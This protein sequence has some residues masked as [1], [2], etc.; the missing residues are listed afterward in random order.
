MKKILFLFLIILPG[1]SFAQEKGFGFRQE[2]TG[3]QSEDWHRFHLDQKI[4]SRLHPG[5]FDLRIYRIN[6]NDTL[7][8]PYILDQGK[9]VTIQASSIRIL[10]ENYE[11][12]CCSWVSFELNREKPVNRLELDIKNKEFDKYLNLEGSED[13]KTWKTIKEKVRITR[14]DNAL[15]KFNHTLIS[16]PAGK[17]RMLRVAF[18]DDNSEKLTVS[19][20]KAWYTR[21]VEKSYDLLNPDVQYLGET[22]KGITSW[23]IRF[24]ERRRV[25]SLRFIPK[26]NSEYFRSINFLIPATST[27]ALQDWT[28]VHTGTIS[29]LDTSQMVMNSTFTDSLR[30]DVINHDNLSPEF[31]AIEVYSEKLSLVTRL[32]GEG[33]LYLYYGSAKAKEPVYDLAWFAHK[34]PSELPLLQT[35]GEESLIRKEA[36]GEKEDSKIWLWIVIAG[37]G[38]LL[39]FYSTRMLKGVE[40]PK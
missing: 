35:G 11:K 40:P 36:E 29:S 2:L 18:D 12:K 15:A 34:I 31:D 8:M 14:I 19:G 25:S 30:V 3:Q 21:P 22:K 4:I 32:S 10:N 33:A 39:L 38:A 6:G 24:P 26:S 5:L 1:V 17:Y 23:M 9:P 28:L 16:F 27:A 37:V 7:E 20:A 13:G